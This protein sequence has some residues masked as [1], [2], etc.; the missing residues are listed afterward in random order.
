[1]GI[2]IRQSIKSSVVSYL[3]VLLG[4]LNI[5]FIFPLYLSRQEIGLISLLEGIA[6][7]IATFAALGINQIAD[8]YFPYFRDHDQ[9]H[10][11]YFVFLNLVNLLGFVLAG[12]VFWLFRDFWLGFYSKEA[13][14]VQDY[15]WEILLFAFCI[16]T[17]NILESYSRIHLRIVVPN[18]LRQVVIRLVITLSILIYALQWVDF[19]GLVLWRI[20]AYGLMGILMILYLQQLQVLFLRVNF[21]ILKA[22][23]FRELVIYGIFTVVGGAS[24]ILIM[25]IDILMI[26]AMLKTQELGIYVIAYFVGTIVE[27]PRQML[28]QIVSPIISQ[29]WAD[30]N[31]AHINMIY[32]KSSVSQSIVGLLLFLGIWAS[33][34]DLFVLMPNGAAFAGGKYV[35]FYV[36]LTRLV[37][38]FCGVNYEILIQSRYYKFNLATT[39]LL[40]VFIVLTNLIFI[41]WMGIVGAA[42]AT[43]ISFIIYNTIKVYFLWYK[44]RLQPFSFKTVLILGIGMLVYGITEI[45]PEIPGV[46]FNIAFKS[47]VIFT[48]FVSLIY[49]SKVSE[50]Y[51]HIAGAIFRKITLGFHKIFKQ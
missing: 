2:I 8:R 25:K 18:L 3:G 10:Q 4:A 24:A 21:S 22:P 34:D 48:V 42:L 45:L 23:F 13:P 29:A 1:M 7:M 15:F 49:F 14:E 38:M 31:M 12:V 28:S 32:K 20:L 46:L 39:V 44:F 35:V 50:D 16:S 5:L 11:G 30:Q 17:S 36:G 37:H 9:Q 19:Y 27:I 33:I 26:G 6:L 43:L 41:P 40:A 51:N 47:I